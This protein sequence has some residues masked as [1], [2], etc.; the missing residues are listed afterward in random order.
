[1]RKP[2]RLLPILLVVMA[3]LCNCQPGPPK[4]NEAVKKE[5]WRSQAIVLSSQVAL[6]QSRE[7]QELQKNQQNFRALVERLQALCGKGFQVS[8]SADDVSCVAQPPVAEPKKK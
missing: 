1:M 8:W 4:L 6:T 5:A 7:Y 2:L 3:F